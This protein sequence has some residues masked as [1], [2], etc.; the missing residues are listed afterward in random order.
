M[1]QAVEQHST[2]TPR[3]RPH[4]TVRLA[5]TLRIRL[6]NLAQRIIDALDALDAPHADLEPDVDS[7][8]EVEEASAQAVTLCADRHPA[9]HCPSAGQMRAAYQ[10]NGDAVPANLRRF[11]GLFGSAR[12]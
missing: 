5:P 7:E 6:E 9:V 8:E 2:C 3:R 12:A 11:G 10:C 1:P 4:R